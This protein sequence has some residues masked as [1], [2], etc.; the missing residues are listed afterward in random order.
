[1]STRFLPTTPSWA[2]RITAHETKLVVLLL[3]VIAFIQSPGLTVADTKHDL[4]VN[5][6]G[7]LHGA[8]EFFAPWGLQNQAYGYLWPQG[9]FFTVFSFL[10]P[11]VVQRLWWWLLFALAYTGTVALLKNLACRHPLLPALLYTFCPRIL[12]TVGAISSEAWVVALVPWTVAP[13]VGRGRGQGPRPFVSVIAVACMGAVNA[14]ATLAALVPAGLVLVSR[15]AWKALTVWLVGVTC[16]SVWWIGPLLILGKY[17]PPFTDYIESSFVT[18]YWLNPLEILRGTTSWAPFVDNERTAGVLLITVPLLILATVVVAAVGLRGSA[19]SPWVGMLVVGVVALSFTSPLLDGTLAAFR[20]LHKFT[21]LVTLPLVVGVAWVVDRVGRTG[22][23]AL[24]LVTVV[25]ISPALSG[26][27]APKGAYEE[28]PEYYQEAAAYVN[29]HAAD[30]TTLLAPERSFARENWGWTRDEPLQPLLTVPW[31]TRDAIPIHNPEF[32]R[33]LDGIMAHPSVEALEGFGIGYV[34]L[35]EPEESWEKALHGVPHRDFGPLSVYEIDPDNG[36]RRGTP[37]TVAGGGESVALLDYLHGP[38]MWQL[39]EGDAIIVTDTPALVER[40]YGTLTGATSGIL[41]P[42]ETTGIKNPVKDYASVGPRTAVRETGGH[43]THGPDEADPTRFGGANP[44]HSVTA[45]VDGFADTAWYGTWLELHPDHPGKL[46]SLALTKGEATVTAG[47]REFVTGSG[48]ITLPESVSSVRVEPH[49]GGLAEVNLTDAPIRRIVTVPDTSPNVQ[50]FVFSGTGRL[51]REFTAPRDMEVT[52]T[53]AGDAHVLI[54]GSPATSPLTLTQG[55]HTVSTL[56]PWVRLTTP[57]FALPV[58]GEF[59]KT[60][61]SANP[62]YQSDGDPLVLGAGQQGFTGG[63][64]KVTFAPTATFQR[65]L[66]FGLVLLTAML[67]ISFALRRREFPARAPF[68]LPSWILLILVG[69]ALGPW[70][71]LAAVA[72]Y[73]LTRWV[74]PTL[75]I[76]LGVGIPGI[77]LALAPWPSPDYPAGSLAV[78]LFIAVALGACMPVAKSGH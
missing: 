38:G 22:F 40:N 9:L 25:A 58:G 29:A 16:V 63:S 41:A 35:R 14:T 30:T 28:V 73:A 57:D 49:G 8:V 26:Q 65:L 47:G 39:V 4:T 76:S 1:M 72:G 20:N 7:F 3:G 46:L 36:P 74:S 78:V 75:L 24:G 27:L 50:E 31:V 6:W 37:V 69:A 13:L 48:K 56:A 67:I 77:W 64:G 18:T 21:P 59:V 51:T 52:V 43:V 44:E 60:T 55:S 34:V 68:R 23:V 66:L 33:G 19:G 71:F 61:L 5:P 70:A 62:G 54:D 32:I 2:T 11:W 53:A 42:G 12:T 45:A 17:A 10:P 15:R